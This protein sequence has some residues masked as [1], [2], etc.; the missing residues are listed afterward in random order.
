MQT[1]KNTVCSWAL[2][3]L[4]LRKNKEPAQSLPETKTST[5]GKK[6][7]TDTVTKEL[8]SLTAGT[9]PNPCW[10]LTTGRNSYHYLHYFTRTHF[11]V[12]PWV[13]FTTSH[14]LAW[15]ISNHFNIHHL[16]KF[17]SLRWAREANHTYLKIRKQKD[18]N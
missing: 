16:I 9:K 1:M 12:T 6:K 7:Q 10:K 18:R 4:P 2:K 15:F 8:W 3:E 17:S 5:K 11:T 14:S 13:S